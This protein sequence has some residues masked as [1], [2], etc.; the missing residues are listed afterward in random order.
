MM[1]VRNGYGKDAA[2]LTVVADKAAALAWCEANGFGPLSIQMR[3]DEFRV[4]RLFDPIAD[5]KV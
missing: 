1:K 2:V 3:S 5:L 4:A